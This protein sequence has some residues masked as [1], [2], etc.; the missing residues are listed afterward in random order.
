MENEQ[1][2]NLL[3]TYELVNRLKKVLPN[4]T[5]TEFSDEVNEL[6]SVVFDK[7]KL[8]K[9]PDCPKR[10]KIIERMDIYLQDSEYKTDQE[11]YYEHYIRDLHDSIARSNKDFEAVKMQL[12]ESKDAFQSIDRTVIMREAEIA[13]L[14]TTL[15]IMR[16]KRGFIS[17]LFGS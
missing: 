6:H 17:R 4:F 3:A 1:A 12:K 11:E 9:L 7:R 16:Q 14:E 10:N 13:R 2:K 8:E 5:V 15:R